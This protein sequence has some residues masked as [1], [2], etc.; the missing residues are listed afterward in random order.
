MLQSLTVWV[1]KAAYR[2]NAAVFAKH[3]IVG[4][5]FRNIHPSFQYPCHSRIHR[6]LYDV[7]PHMYILHYASSPLEENHGY[8]RAYLR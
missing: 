7:F 6:S 3:I 4:R 5:L 1:H 2:Y 8:F